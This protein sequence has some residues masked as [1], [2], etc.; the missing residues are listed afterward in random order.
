[1]KGKKSRQASYHIEDYSCDICGKVLSSI[2]TLE[3]HK[4]RHHDRKY[5]SYNCEECDKQFTSEFSLKVHV[6]AIHCGKFFQ[7]ELCESRFSLKCHLKRHIAKVHDDNQEEISC[8]KCNKL[9]KGRDNL[10]DHIKNVH[11]TKSF[12][13]DVCEKTFPKRYILDRHKLTHDGAEK[14]HDEKVCREK[15]FTCN[16]C[17]FRYFSKVELNRHQSRVHFNKLKQILCELCDKTFNSRGGL[18]THIDIFHDESIHLCIH[19]EFKF[20]SNRALRRHIISNHMFKEK[21]EGKCDLCNMKFENK[22]RLLYHQRMKHTLVPSKNSRLVSK[23]GQNKN[24]LP[25]CNLCGKEFKFKT[26]IR[27]HMI[28]VHP[29]KETLVTCDLCQKSFTSKG[30]LVRHKLFVHEGIKKCILCRT[31][32]S[33]TESF[34]QHAETHAHEKFVCEFCGK[35]FKNHRTLK[36]HEKEMH[37]KVAYKCKY[38]EKT[39]K[40]K[41]EVEKHMRLIHKEIHLQKTLNMI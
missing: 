16:F 3:A 5:A 39:H 22:H 20:P 14:S 41:D 21:F 30:T 40:R 35:H 10:K 17:D 7:C 26:S 15:K 9:L 38:C 25:K 32:F 18:S 11:E 34:K 2:N 31:T 24:N 6:N 28:S 23:D 19:C 37:G 33:D 4:Q 1:M 29:N 27:N 36:R 13:C 12:E 8:V